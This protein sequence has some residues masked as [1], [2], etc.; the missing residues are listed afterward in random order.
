MVRVKQLILDAVE[1]VFSENTGKLKKQR[2]GDRDFVTPVDIELSNYLTEGLRRIIPGSAVI[3]E[4]SPDS[5]SRPASCQWI[6]DPIDGT[7]NLIYGFPL[8]AVSV[9]LLVDNEPVLGLVYNPLS[10]ELFTA[11]KGHGAY[12]GDQPIIVNKEN[13]LANALVLVE[14]DPYLDRDK[15]RSPDLIKAVFRDCLDYRVTGSAALDI[16]FIAAGRGSVFFTQSLKPW[17]YAGGSI[18]LLEA[19][20]CISQWDNTP[21]LFREKHNLLATNGVLHR[22]MIERIEIFLANG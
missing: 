5:L 15:N 10:R 18:I 4:E 3:S 17:D 12:L 13:I 19:G 11:I 20:G 16:C 14:T 1:P 22:E 6:I 8:F 2:K 21:I 9:G 7:S